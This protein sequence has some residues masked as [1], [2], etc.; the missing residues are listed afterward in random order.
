MLPC[1]NGDAPTIVC[2]QENFLLKNNDYFVRQTLPNHHIVFKPAVKEGLEGRPMC[3]MFIAIPMLFE[4]KIDEVKVNSFR[5]QN[6]ILSLPS[7]KFIDN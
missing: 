3:G 5:I 6:I 7:S 4:D 1:L 2:N